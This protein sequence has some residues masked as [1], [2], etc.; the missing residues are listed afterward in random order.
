MHVR[1]VGTLIRVL[2][3]GYYQEFILSNILYLTRKEKFVK[4]KTL[5][6]LCMKMPRR[7]GHMR[8]SKLK[9]RLLGQ[10]LI[11][12]ADSDHDQMQIVYMN[13]KHI[14]AV[15]VINNEYI[16]GEGSY[17]VEYTEGYDDPKEEPIRE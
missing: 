11:D 3:W 15:P 8:I 9:A 12:A 17:F 13:Y 1:C 7:G 6:N 14:V 2:W 4:L 16:I 10:A 5:Y